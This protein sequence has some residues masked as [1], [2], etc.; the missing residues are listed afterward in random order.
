[1]G[2]LMGAKIRRIGDD[3]LEDEFQDFSLGPLMV[4]DGGDF[5]PS[6]KDEK[7]NWD[8][9]IPKIWKKKNMFQPPTSGL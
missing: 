2:P 4:F 7:V 8:D 5:N 1:M 3:L 6:E 9:E